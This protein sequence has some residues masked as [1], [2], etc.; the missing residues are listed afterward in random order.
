MTEHVFGGD[1]TNE[2]LNLIQ[3]YLRAY[4][5]IFNR[6]ERA[7]YFTT[8]YVDAFAGTGRRVMASRRVKRE[9]GQAKIFDD[10]GD[11]EMEAALKGSVRIALEVAPPFGRYVFIE[12]NKKRAAE[13]KSLR[14]EFPAKASAIHIEEAD[15]NDHLKQWCAKT[16]WKRHRAVVFLDPYGMQVEWAT[17]EAIAKT[18]AIDLW[19]LFPLGVAVNRLLTKDKPPPKKWAAQ[20]T[21]LFGTEEWRTAF[22]PKQQTHTLFGAEE[23]QRKE[24][25]FARIGDFFLK[26]L[27][28]VF[29][30]V[31]PDPRVLKNSKGVPIYLLCFAAGNLKGAKTAVKIAQDILLKEL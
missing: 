2:K 3:K 14:R 26:R 29:A 12:K 24:A 1:W 19:I 31:A 13:L 22:Y 9:T 28:T 18:K 17:I 23:S 15:A 5:T 30:K 8:I 6:N 27:R 20:L 11:L 16:D 10:A 21:R 7:K 25:D 4:T